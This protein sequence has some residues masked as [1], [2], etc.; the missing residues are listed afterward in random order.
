M[1]QQALAAQGM[2]VV[3]EQGVSS[4]QPAPG[5]LSGQRILTMLLKQLEA[6]RRPSGWA[7]VA[8]FACE[9]DGSLADPL[10]G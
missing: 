1:H 5:S 4:L 6:L 10:A 8:D 3:F 2:L 7:K 9:I